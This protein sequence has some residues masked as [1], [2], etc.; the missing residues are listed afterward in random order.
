MIHNKIK[1]GE[2]RVRVSAPRPE[3]VLNLLWNNH[4]YISEIKKIDYI[5][6]NFKVPYQDFEKTK[7]LVKRCNGKLKVIGKSGRILWYIKVKRHLSLIIGIGLFFVV[8]YVMSNYIWAIDIRTENNLTP[9]EVRQQLEKIGIKPGLKK[10]NI[11]VYEIERKMEDFNDQIMWIRTRIEGSTLKLVIQEKIN[12]P[13]IQ[14]ENPNQVVA[15]MDGEVKRIFTTMGNCAVKPGDIVKKGDILILPIQGREGF[16]KDVKPKGTIIANTFYEKSMEVQIS[17]KKLMRT[18]KRDNDIFLS[19]WGKKIYLKKAINGFKSYDKI[20]E[21]K[22]FFN[23]VTYFEK[24][25]E[26]VNEDKDEAVKEAEERLT[27]S[28][29]KYLSNDAK[30]IDNKLTV[31]DIGEGKIRVNLVFT[32]EQDIAENIM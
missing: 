21:S 26:D 27:Q 9:L 19:F 32:V 1:Y 22:Y 13:S 28:L 18:G 20:E 15:K 24:A 25:E 5:T 4:I 2:V 16:E 10:S 29:K 14:K 7:E 30:I 23:N 17:G 11:N 8:L 31:E 3:N 6:V 12:P